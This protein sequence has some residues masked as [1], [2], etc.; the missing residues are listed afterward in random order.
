MAQ[1][2]PG[3]TLWAVAPEGGWDISVGGLFSGAGNFLT[4]IR[5]TR[6]LTSQGE[7]PLVTILCGQIMK[8]KNLLSERTHSNIKYHFG[9]NS[10]RNF[11]YQFHH[12]QHDVPGCVDPYTLRTHAHRAHITLQIIFATHTTSIDHNLSS[13]FRNIHNDSRLV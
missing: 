1:T 8:L 10:I 12:G 7:S 4:K 3:L 11:I 5:T 6:S 9:I 13:Y 2:L